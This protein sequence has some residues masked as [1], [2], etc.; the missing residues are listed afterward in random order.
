LNEAGALLVLT[1]LMAA[2][3]LS[4][5]LRLGA[6]MLAAVAVAAPALVGAQRLIALF[7]TRHIASRNRAAS[8]I[9]EYLQG[10]S[11]LR[12]FNMAGEGFKRL[13]ESLS[14]LKKDSIWLEGASGIPIMIFAMILDLGL[15]ALLVCATWLMSR[16]L[17]TVTVF[18]MFVVIGAKFFEPLLS[19]G[20]FFSELKYMGLA[21]G[22]VAAALEEK[23]LP[24]SLPAKEPRGCAVEFKNVT[25]GYDPSRPVIKDLSLALPQNSLTALV[26]PS[27]GGKT[28][29]A[30]LMARFWDVGQG[31]V[32]IGGASV[33]S[34]EPERLNS[35]FSFVF[36]DVYLFE[37]TIFENIRA[38]DRS[39]SEE[40]VRKAAEKA[41]CGEFIANLPKGYLT[42]VGEGG[43]AL[44]GGERQRISIARAML[45]NAPIV[46]LDE[47]TASLDPENELSIQTAIG[48]LVKN[49]TVVAIAHRLRTVVA[50]SQIAV[51][52]GGRLLELGD[53]GS[54]L[55]KGGLYAS[56][57]AEQKLA[58]GWRLPKRALAP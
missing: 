47:A 29:L 40:E 1:A 55:E 5:D 12:S 8:R 16:G 20:V 53:H 11:V 54:L 24:P 14:A 37:D 9:L 6:L 49:K 26:G 44:S 46:V 33:K 52:S 2:G 50:A 4:A 32:L 13:E 56:L 22:R 39:A 57:W 48:E 41:M 38:G 15:A 28:T 27:G 31:E 7:G 10:M 17:V 21:A 35:L 58:G 36:Q 34:I 18:I 30:S 51:I 42:R 43:T 3:F 45:K 25:F 23:P 19:F